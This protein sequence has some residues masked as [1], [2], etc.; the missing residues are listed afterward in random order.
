LSGLA[1]GGTSGLGAELPAA[2]YAMVV[3]VHLLK[4]LGK[5]PANQTATWRWRWM[6]SNRID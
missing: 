3:A 4:A 1:D 6:D 5:P 2:L